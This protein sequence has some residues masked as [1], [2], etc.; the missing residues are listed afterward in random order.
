MELV[1][2]KKD[3]TKDKPVKVGHEDYMA[4]LEREGWTRVN[5]SSP[6]K[7]KKKSKKK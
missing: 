3:G 7:S 1:W 5:R 6:K 2:F 4:E